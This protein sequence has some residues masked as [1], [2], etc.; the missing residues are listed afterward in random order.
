MDNGSPAS[1]NSGETLL[2]SVP[3]TLDDCLE[4]CY[5]IIS[6]CVHTC[7]CSSSVTVCVCVCVCENYLTTGDSFLFVVCVCR[8]TRPEDLGTEH[9]IK[10]SKCHSYQVSFTV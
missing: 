1:T 10:C 5:Y 2:S 9:K 6:N 7:T 4:R 8:F 3:S